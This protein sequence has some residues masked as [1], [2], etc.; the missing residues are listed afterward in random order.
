MDVKIYTS[1]TCGYC[2]QAKRFLTERGVRFIEYDVSRD[3]AAAEEMVRTTGHM[4]V[5][6]IVIDGQV[7]IGFDQARLEQLLAQHHDAKRPRFGL[8]VADASRVA[9]RLGGAPALG[10]LVGAVDSS[11]PGERAGLRQGDVITEVNLRPIH[12]ADDLEQVLN[13]LTYG[14][15]V[16]VVFLRG[17]ETSRAEISI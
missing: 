15:R 9:Q 17:Q 16:T 2:H 13:G 3:R 11:S 12:N 4:G 5:P 1:P 14:S 6:V 7:V 10:A 8:K